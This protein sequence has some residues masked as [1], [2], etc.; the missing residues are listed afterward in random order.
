MQVRT[1][2]E[3]FFDFEFH[4]IHAQSRTYGGREIERFRLA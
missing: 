1:G 4:I 3:G 2:F